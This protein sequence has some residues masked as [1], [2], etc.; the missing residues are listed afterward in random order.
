M[1]QFNT[2]LTPFLKGFLAYFLPGFLVI[3]VMLLIHYEVAIKAKK[4]LYLNNEKVT[5]ELTRELVGSNLTSMTADVKMLAHYI[6]SVSYRPESEFKQLLAGYFSRLSLYRGNYD[7]IRFIDVT[8]QERVRTEHDDQG[9]RLIPDQG[10]R[11]KMGR[12]YFDTTMA[13][14]SNQV[15]ISPLDLNIEDGQVEQPPQPTI[16][17]GTK[18]FDTQGNILGIALINY[19]AFQL[20]NNLATVSPG[21]NEHLIL[22]NP[23]GYAL[24]QPEA[25]QDLVYRASNSFADQYP[26]LWSL[27][28]E[29]DAGQLSF[30]GHFFTFSKL[31]EPGSGQHWTMISFLDKAKLHQVRSIFTQENLAM[32]GA[33]LLTLVV[34]SLMSAKNKKIQRQISAQRSYERNFRFILEK[35]Q[36][37]AVTVR[38]DGKISFCN[39]YFLNLVGYKRE[40]VIGKQWS[41]T[42]IP[43]ELQDDV[44]HALSQIFQQ[45]ANQPLSEGVVMT[46]AKEVRLVSWTSTFNQNDHAKVSAVTFVGEDITETSMEKDRLRQLS[47]AVEHSQNAVMITNLEGRIISVNPVF[48]DMTGYQPEEAIGKSPSILQSGEVAPAEYKELWSTIRRGEQW[49]GIFHNKKKS[50]ELYWESARISPVKDVNGLPLYYVAVKQDITEQVR[51]KKEVEHQTQETLKNEK[52]AAVGRAANMITHDLR[53]PLSSVKMSLQLASRQPDPKFTELFQISLEQVKYMEAILEDLMSYSRPEQL[54]PEWLEVNKLVE[55]AL[56]TCQK[57]INESGVN[58][59]CQLQPNLPTLFGDKTKLRQVL[60]NLIVNAVQ[61]AVSDDSP[62][63]CVTT[64]LLLTQGS[65]QIVLNIHNN[66]QSIDPCL[67][68]KAFEPFF[69]TKAK[70]TGLGLAIVK[71]I[72]EQHQGRIEL[73]ARIKGGTEAQ[74]ILPISVS[75]QSNQQPA[76]TK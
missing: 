43:E 6:Q 48:T 41:A 2:Q 49:S 42:F 32:Y 70:G 38:S 15:Y 59:Q 35:I 58:V 29:Q 10:L 34:F 3:L 9:T 13:L 25:P 18:A 46:K 53:N 64:N 69:T 51:L 30:E 63:V 61:A 40:E 14:M 21:F 1:L 27:I 7:Q 66:G 76:W 44:Q 45:G 31:A 75:P 71:G 73:A 24:I 52:L 47:H 72:I 37:V 55:M 60:Q 26:K 23:Q 62:T 28:E 16:R 33:L 11:N 68:D 36:L 54:K 50:G 8:G 65:N 20:I 5:V 22:I 17:V 19:D 56:A 39:D 67:R 57:L 74:I 4:E 12:Y